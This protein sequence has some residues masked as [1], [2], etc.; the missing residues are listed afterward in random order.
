MS[1]PFNLVMTV[2]YRLLK[3]FFTGRT[4]DPGWRRKGDRSKPRIPQDLEH[5]PVEL[6]R[7]RR[8]GHEGD[9]AQEGGNFVRIQRMCQRSQI[10]TERC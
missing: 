3:T 6:D 2:C 5:R 4:P 8:H 7:R 9:G 1:N 10:R